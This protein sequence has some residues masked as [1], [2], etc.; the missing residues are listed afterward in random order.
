MKTKLF[1]FS[2]VFVLFAG[3]TR[4]VTPVETI[5]DTQPNRL[6]VTSFES[7]DN[8]DIDNWKSPGPPI[9]K[10][11]NDVPLNGGKFSIFLKARSLGAYVTNEIPAPEGNK[12]YK[13]TFWS[14]STQDP[15]S[16]VVYH[17]VGDKKTRIEGKS[18]ESKVWT[19][20]TLNFNLNSSSN[21]K[22]FIELGG[23]IFASPQ[24]YTFFDL[25]DLQLVD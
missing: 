22:I 7:G 5:I 11:S 4:T 23:S 21:D 8:A 25:I 16:L 17:M 14:K 12:N 1:L 13:L 20:Y 19:S 3:C 10:F 18:I 15:G 6:L 9:V 2:L 24:G